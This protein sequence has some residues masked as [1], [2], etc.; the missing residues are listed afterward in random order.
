MSIDIGDIARV[1]V[2]A[3]KVTQSPVQVTARALVQV[4]RLPCP[5]VED[6]SPPT[7]PF[8]TLWAA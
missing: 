2:V 1:T 4:K 7:G 5:S 6:S 8:T 3:D